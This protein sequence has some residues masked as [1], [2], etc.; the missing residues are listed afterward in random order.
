MVTGGCVPEREIR[1][2]GAY[3]S[4]PEIEECNG[5]YFI[6]FRPA[7]ADKAVKKILTEFDRRSVADV[8]SDRLRVAPLLRAY[9]PVC[10]LSADAAT[11]LEQIQP[12][13]TLGLTWRGLETG[14]RFG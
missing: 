10:A 1:F 5:K 7:I 11:R 9:L 6:N 2:S 8:H 13:C 14:S 3:V 12:G 4:P